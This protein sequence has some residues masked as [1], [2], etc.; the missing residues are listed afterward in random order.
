MIA[1]FRRKSKHFF[2]IFYFFYVY[3]LLLSGNYRISTIFCA[4]KGVLHIDMRIGRSDLA[5]D[6]A[7]KLAI[8]GAGVRKIPGVRVLESLRRGYR[9]TA[10]TVETAEGAEAL[11]KPVGRYVTIELTPYLARKDGFFVHGADCLAEE[12]RALLPKEPQGGVLVAGLGNRDMAADAIGAASVENLLVTRHLSRNVGQFA[13]VS[14]VIPGVSAS[15]GM[16]TLEVL[17]GLVRETGVGCVVVDAL[18]AA[19]RKRLC[20]TIQLSDTGLCPGSGVGNHR[21]PLNTDSLH[22]P[23]VAVGVPTVMDASEGGEP[24]FVTLRDIDSRVREIGRLLGY[25]V[26][27]ALQPSLS[28]EDVTGLLG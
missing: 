15:T 13:P 20:S 25:G 19:H 18:C 22:V 27:L 24:L 2:G 3:L 26:T 7:E 4:M 10:I 28:V 14:A 5:L 12:L 17:R 11:D 8:S 6:A 1:L 21:L 23:V 9:V 16:E